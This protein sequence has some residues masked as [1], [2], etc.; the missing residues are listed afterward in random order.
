MDQT[1]SMIILVVYA[2]FGTLAVK[3]VKSECLHIVAEF[4]TGGC[5]GAVLGD[6]IW[7]LF[8]GWAC[9]PIMIFHWLIFGRK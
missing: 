7:G 1:T 5:L 4:T 8:F 2:I 9:I 3:Y 6:L